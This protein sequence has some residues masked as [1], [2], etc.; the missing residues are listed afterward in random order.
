MLLFASDDYAALTELS[1]D[2]SRLAD[3]TLRAK[4]KDSIK[5]DISVYSRRFLDITKDILKSEPLTPSSANLTSIWK[6]NQIVN[7]LT[8]KIAYL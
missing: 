3:D 8:F 6:E 2:V 5:P 7:N 1:L 4:F